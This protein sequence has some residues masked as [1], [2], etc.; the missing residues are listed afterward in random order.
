MKQDLLLQAT[1][2]RKMLIL[3]PRP[4][5]SGGVST[6]VA[7]LKGNWQAREEYFYRGRSSSNP[8]L[9]MVQMLSGYAA[10][11]LKCINIHRDDIIFINTSMDRKANKRDMLFLY[12]ASLFSKRIFVFVHGWDQNYYNRIS[13][14]NRQQL[15]KASKLFVLSQEFRQSLLSGGYPGKVI[16]ETTVIDNQFL[17][18]AGHAAKTQKNTAHFLYLARLEKEK[19]ILLLLEAFEQLAGR[20]P[21]ITLDIAGFG[22]LEKE[23][24]DYVDSHPGIPVRY[25]GLVSGE[26]KRILFAQ[27]NIFVLPTSH[28]E[29]MP[30]SILEAMAAGQAVITTGA[31]ALKEFFKNNIMGYT[32]SA[33]TTDCLV[34]TMEKALNRTNEIRQIGEHNAQYARQHFTVAKVI[35]RMEKE[36]WDY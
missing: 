5:L 4:A 17:Q 26:P 31:G 3:S 10:F 29:G 9:R 7:A 22:S 14:F 8:L 30:I 20:Y 23:V 18:Y 11:F 24:T 36:L 1:D 12:I 16:V 25:H 21:G 34:E 35:D 2:N 19:G 15:F 32:L 28:G 13:H 27:A 6:Y 33:A